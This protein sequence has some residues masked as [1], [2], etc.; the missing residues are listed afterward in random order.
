M[1]PPHFLMHA[2]QPFESRLS[3]SPILLS[4]LLTNP[5]AVS[6]AQAVHPCSKTL[7]VF[8]RGVTRGLVRTSAC[9]RACAGLDARAAAIVMRAI[10]RITAGGRTVVCTIHQASAGRAD[11]ALPCMLCRAAVCCAE[12]VRRAGWHWAGMRPP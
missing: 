9:M 11:C 6:K 7:A 12:L 10:K 8:V 4:C 1:W 2:P 3:W 5:L